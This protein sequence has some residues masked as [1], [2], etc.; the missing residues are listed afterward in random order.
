MY[1][2]EVVV[3]MGYLSYVGIL[4][5]VCMVLIGGLDEIFFCCLKDMEF[6]WRKFCCG[7]VDYFLLS[8]FWCLGK[9]KILRIWYDN[10]GDDLFWYF[11]RVMVYDV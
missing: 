8:V 9:L 2:Y 3:Y 4:F 11:F 6:G 7:N 1:M 5:E 10:I